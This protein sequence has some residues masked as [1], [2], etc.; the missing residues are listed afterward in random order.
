VTTLTETVD[1]LAT[2]LKPIAAF[3][4]NVYTDFR[5]PPVTPAA[6]I[7]P[8]PIDYGLPLSGRGAQFNVGVLVLVGAIDSDKQTSLFP[9]LDWSGVSSVYAAVGADPSLGGL[10]VKARVVGTEPPGL[11]EFYD[12]APAYGCQLIVGVFAS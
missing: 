10:D 11:V 6:L 9:F 8:Q 4:N 2:A 3:K 12:G 7:G 1:G 5:R